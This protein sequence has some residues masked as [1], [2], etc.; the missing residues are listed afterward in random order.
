MSSAA[1]PSER[2]VAGLAD[3]LPARLRLL[4]VV[5]EP[6][7]PLPGAESLVSART[8]GELASPDPLLRFDL[9]VLADADGADGPLLHRLTHEAGFVHCPSLEAGTM[10]ASGFEP[11][12]AAGLW[13]KRGDPGPEEYGDDYLARWGDND[14]LANAEV[15]AGDIL[16]HLPAGHDASSV[17]VLDVGCLNGYV[18]ESLR[19]AGVVHVYG[20][21][22]SYPLAI[23][24]TVDRYHLPAI[25]VG[26]FTSNDYP[27]A[28]FDLTVCMEVLEHLPPPLTEPF[29]V[30]L[31]RV[32]GPEG[33]VLVSTSE[34]P[35]VDPTHINCRRRSEWY[36][37]FAKAGLV[38]TGRQVIYEGFNSFVLRPART[39]GEARRA[40]A[41]AMA[42]Y[43]AAR[44]TGKARPIRSNPWPG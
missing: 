19:R 12:G 36:Y 8:P 21:D 11:A 15:T 13:V 6:A 3:V 22:I 2:P 41:A 4:G 10:T 30:E 38:R 1:V 28:A 34:D 44:M 37:L 9:V 33:R 40:V 23:T 35:H 27:S 43:A 29:L 31:A 42:G 32:T 16:A 5:G 39:P 24:H 17:R 20:T 25:T 7:V 26:D 18:M 14:F